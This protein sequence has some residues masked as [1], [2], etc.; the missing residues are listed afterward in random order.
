MRSPKPS[1]EEHEDALATLDEARRATI[2]IGQLKGVKDFWP[3]FAAAVRR[4]PEKKPAGSAVRP[5]WRWA[6]GTA[7]LLA[8]VGMVVLVP[9]L[10]RRGRPLAVPAEVPLSFRVDSV[11]IE[12]KPA[13]AFVFHTQDPDITY[14]WV[15]RQL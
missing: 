11:I 7:G 6:L 15:E 2:S 5:A 13:Q 4:E 14:V 1:R 9:W 10:S 8:V 3:G 12:E